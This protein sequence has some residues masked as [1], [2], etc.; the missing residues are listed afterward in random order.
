M[1]LIAP[2]AMHVSLI[3]FDHM[4]PGKIPKLEFITH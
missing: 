2:V 4:I 1:N 3:E